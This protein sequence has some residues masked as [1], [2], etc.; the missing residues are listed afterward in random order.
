M[1]AAEFKDQGS[2]TPGAAQIPLRLPSSM[3]H[4][5]KLLT[6]YGLPLSV[7]LDWLLEILIHQPLFILLPLILPM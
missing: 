1:A 6:T 3:L 2:P 7:L 4:L 5:S